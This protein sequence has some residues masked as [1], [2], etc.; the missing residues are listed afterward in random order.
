MC[1]QDTG[2]QSF[3][4]S[5]A[6]TEYTPHTSRSFRK[7]SDYLDFPVDIQYGEHDEK[8]VADYLSNVDIVHCH[9]MYRYANGWGPINPKAKW[10]IHQHGRPGN[11]D[12]NQVKIDDKKR[13]AKRFVSTINLLPYVDNNQDRWIPSPIRLSE[14]VPNKPGDGI[15]RIA[16][17]PTNPAYKKT[18]LLKSVVERLKKKY[19]VELVLI[20]NKPHREALELKSKCDITFDQIHLCYGNSGLEGMA[21]GQATLV[22]MADWTRDLIKQIVGYEPYVYVDE[23]GLEETLEKLITNEQ[24]RLKMGE[25]GRKYIETW[26]DDRKVAE[27]MVRIYE[28]L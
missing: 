24:Y 15:I 14:F 8:F 4:L 13:K 12:W 19:P 22:G 2:G 18:E 11:V 6:I 20:Q 17:T 21:F 5:R 23:G 27:K 26:H 25:I 16:H 28:N 1:G 3:R 9:N 7:A 10:L